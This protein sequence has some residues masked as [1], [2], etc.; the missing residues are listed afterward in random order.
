MRDWKSI[1]YNLL[2]QD[3]TLLNLLE[4]QSGKEDKKIYYIQPDNA[5]IFDKM[6]C[7]TYQIDTIK[8]ALTGDDRM[9]ENAVDITFHIWSKEPA[10]QIAERIIEVVDSS[11]YET[12]LLGGGE[13]R[14]DE[15]I[16]HRILI[17]E[18]F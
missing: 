16:Y 9:K 13:Y 6:P 10:H 7:I 5:D 14:D 15:G 11:I 12:N 8:P 3:T 2:T 17:F 1:I 4:Y 18:F